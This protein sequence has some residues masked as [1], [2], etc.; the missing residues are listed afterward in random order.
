MDTHYNTN[1]FSG[2]THQEIN[3]LILNLKGYTV[4]RDEKGLGWLLCDP[5]G[6][7]MYRERNGSMTPW[8]DSEEQAREYTPQWATYL[9]TAWGLLREFPTDAEYPSIAFTGQ[10]TKFFAV[11]PGQDKRWHY[12]RLIAPTASRAICEAWLIW[13]DTR[14]DS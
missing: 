7:W 14:H 12:I 6:D 9:D 11:V 4:K 8:Y 3:R 5:N 13:Q 10:G 1:K 2:L